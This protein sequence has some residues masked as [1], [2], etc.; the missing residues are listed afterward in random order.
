MLV[1]ILKIMSSIEF[2]LFFFFNIPR[3]KTRIPRTMGSPLSPQRIAVCC[4]P[5]P[6]A[7]A[8]NVANPLLSP[9]LRV[10]PGARKI[11]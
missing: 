3:M 10:A 6:R 7:P 11:N 4:A 8:I 9:L 2:F 5:T 1:L